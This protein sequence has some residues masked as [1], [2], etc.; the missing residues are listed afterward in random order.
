VGTLVTLDLPTGSP[1]ADLPW[2]IT[3][4][5]LG[6]EEDWEPVVCGPYERPHAL[7]LAQAVVADEDLMAVVEPVQPYVSVD[8]IRGEITASRVA[9]AEAD[10]VHPNGGSAEHHADP[11]P[12]E[13]GIPPSP[14]EVR[15]GFARLAAH[16]S[17]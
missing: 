2:V 1:V 8:Q 10:L 16:L 9:A 7:A 15:A 13:P 3:I 5:S 17:N 6:D 4:G 11:H 12:V 14:D